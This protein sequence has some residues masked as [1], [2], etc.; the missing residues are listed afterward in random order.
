M[1]NQN[2][3]WNKIAES[4][5]NFRQKPFKSVESFLESKKGNIL[6]LGS[7]SGRNC[8][9]IGKHKKYYCVDF[10]DEMLK[11]AKENLKKKKLDGEFFKTNSW[12]IPFLD[13]FFDAT[14]C[15]SV[16]Q[17]INSKENR[18]L[19][20]KEIYRTLKKNGTALIS[21]WG[22]KHKILKNKPKESMISW[23]LGDE[24]INRYNYIYDVEE[25]KQE[26]LDVGFKILSINNSEM[27]EFVVKK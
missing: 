11:F 8:I 17:C 4:W 10:S 27:I 5:N 3:V 6:D 25:L 21:T 1:D 15:M 16:L 14:I 9:N 26:L 22:R 18:V 20:I 7:G 13:N 23:N 19:T 2:N 24:K 12:S